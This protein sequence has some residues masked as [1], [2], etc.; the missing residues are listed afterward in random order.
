MWR[1][2]YTLAEQS[3]KKDHETILHDPSEV[4]LNERNEKSTKGLSLC[5]KIPYFSSGLVWWHFSQDI[6]FQLSSTPDTGK[7]NLKNNPGNSTLQLDLCHGI[8]AKH[9]QNSWSI[10]LFASGTPCYA[11]I[12]MQSYQKSYFVPGPCYLCSHCPPSLHW[13]SRLLTSANPGEEGESTPFV[14]IPGTPFSALRHIHISPSPFYP[15]GL[16]WSAAS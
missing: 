10:C 1:F 2:F 15:W 6:R 7:N 4:Q 16:C 13:I 5:Q 9:I 3:L 8:K 14:P 12:Q 11:K